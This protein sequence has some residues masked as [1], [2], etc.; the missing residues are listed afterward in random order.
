VTP[1]RNDSETIA[2]VVCG[3]AFRRSGRRLHCSDAC[4]QAAWRRRSQAPS[5]PL[6]AKP[7]TVYRCP[8]CETRLRGEQYCE[9]CHTFARRLGPGGCCPE[10]DEPISITELLEPDQFV[11]RQRQQTKRRR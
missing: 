11:A 10:C 2:C 4:R 9:D 1:V 5:E 3:T 7:D 6:V 8:K